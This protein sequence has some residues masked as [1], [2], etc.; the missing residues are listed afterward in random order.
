MTEVLDGFERSAFEALGARRDVWR[1]GAGPAVLVLSEMPGITPRVVAFARRVAERGM[2]VALPHLFGDDGR[3]PTAGYLARSLAKGCVAREFTVLATGRSSPIVAWLRA[4]AASEHERAGGPGVGVVGMCF[5][6]GFAL[7]MMAGAP[8]VAPVLSQPSLPFSIG[9]RRA[10]DVGCSVAELAAVK[11]KV[12][13]GAQ[14]LGL[15]FTGDPAVKAARF[16]T[17]RREL[18]DG[19]VAVELDSSPGNPYGHRKGA[20]SVLT[21]D[22]VDR[23]GSPT[24]AALHQVLDFLATRLGVAA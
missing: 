11:A 5:T 17:L 10:A 22:L 24:M 3:E 12:A 18:G 4:L 7:G 15:R 20:H 14:V 21:E 16:E 19:F 9:A 6:G 8:I 23:E 2:S 13:D 1:L